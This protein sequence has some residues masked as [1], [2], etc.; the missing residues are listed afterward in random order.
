MNSRLKIILVI[1]VSVAVV[2][3]VS[4]LAYNSFISAQANPLNFVPS[5]SSFVLKVDYNNTTYYAFGGSSSFGILI[6]IDKNFQFTNSNLTF[7]STKIPIFKYGTIGG[8]S[9][10]KISLYEIIYGYIMNLTSNINYS[11]YIHNP[12]ANLTNFSLYLFQPYSNAII[13][14]NL[15]ELNYSIYSFNHGSNFSHK[16][17]FLSGKGIIQF[18]LSEENVTIWG[19]IT[20]SMAYIF[21]NGNSTFIN[22]LYNESNSPLFAISG[23][24]IIRVNQ[25]TIEFII[26]SKDTK[27]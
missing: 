4:I 24:R 22:S 19:N 18:Y 21:I 17:K 25:T 8:F 6:P 20:K 27:I 3:P 12:F 11:Y 13:I 2:V 10:Y 26:Q 23:L 16:S 14:G 9:V 7:N 15:Q 1:L 5:N